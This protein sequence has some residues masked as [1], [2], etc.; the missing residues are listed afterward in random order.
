MS[1]LT[2]NEIINIWR[3]AKLRAKGYEID[4]TRTKK[5]EKDALE[6]LEDIREA[7]EG[8]CE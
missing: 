2:P 6:D 1:K 5:E 8:Q 7:E 3:I 4:Y